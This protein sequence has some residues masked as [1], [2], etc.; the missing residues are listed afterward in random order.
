MHAH[1]REAVRRVL[2]AIDISEP[3]RGVPRQRVCER[4]VSRIVEIRG[5]C[6]KRR[7]RIVAG[8]G[9][10]GLE[11]HQRLLELGVRGLAHDSPNFAKALLYLCRVATER[12]HDERVGVH[13][14]I[15]GPKRFFAQD[16]LSG[17]Q[18]PVPVTGE[19]RSEE[20]VPGHEGLSHADAVLLGSLD[21]HSRRLE[22]QPR[23]I[24]HGKLADVDPG[25]KVDHDE[26]TRLGQGEHSRE[27]DQ[28]FSNAMRLADADALGDDRV[29]DDVHEVQPFGRHD[30][31][32]R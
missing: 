15:A 4:A 2:G 18:H 30:C 14:Q 31:P 16:A 7:G 20:G 25:A 23:I 32:V 11:H 1:R 17:C 28:C 8:Q 22:P 26:P 6:A 21:S 29:R 27:Q 13:L 3:Q 9:E 19:Q 10:Q 12:P 5:H 24:T